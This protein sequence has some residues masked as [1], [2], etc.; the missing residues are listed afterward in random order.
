M[1]QLDNKVFDIVDAWCIYEVPA[2]RSQTGKEY[3]SY[4]KT[5]ED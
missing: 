4:N 3:P 5:R 2:I 1:H